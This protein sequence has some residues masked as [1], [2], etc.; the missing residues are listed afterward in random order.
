MRADP[1][2]LETAAEPD[3][4]SGRLVAARARQVLRPTGALG[5]LD[6][7][8]VWLARWQRT[9][10]PS[11]D[12]PKALIFAGDH[13]VVDEGVSAYPS[14]VTGAILDALRNGTATAAVMASHLG[15]D[16]EVVDVGVGRPTGNIRVGPALTEEQFHSAVETGRSAVKAS[17][18]I[19]LLVLGEIGIGNTTSAAAICLALLG[20]AAEDWVGPGAGLSPDGVRRKARVVSDAVRRSSTD[21]PLEI[22]RQLGGWE[23]AAIAGA[24]AEARRASVPVLLDG[25]V[26]WAAVMPLERSRPGFLDHCWPSHVSAEPGHAR[27]MA[28][29]GR[30]PLLDLE[31]RLGEASGALAALPLVSLA[32]RSVVD[33]A[34]FEESGLT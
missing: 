17:T 22:L 10:R 12:R 27:L 16:L 29:F 24:A 23:L 4:A 3:E 21:D 32:A 5:R 13:G 8:A 15:V 6:E 2:S 26:V 1:F 7:I 33:V 19:D 11:I 28:P 25:F 20:G 18:D 34:T 31:M 14:S 9:A 30:R